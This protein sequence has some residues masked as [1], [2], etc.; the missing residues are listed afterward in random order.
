[1]TWTR[2]KFGGLVGAS[3]VAALRTRPTRSQTKAR[4]VVIGGGIGGATV[5]KYLVTTSAKLDVTLVEPKQKYTTCFFS[6]LYLAGVR[7]LE[8]LTHDYQTLTKAYGINVIHDAAAAID[9]VAKTVTLAG[10]NKLAYDRAVVAPGIAFKYD[11]IEG[12]DQA[13]TQTIPHA[14]NA[15]GSPHPADEKPNQGAGRRDRGRHWRRDRRQ[16]FGHYLRKTRCNIG[17]AKATHD[18]LLQQSLSRGRS[19]AR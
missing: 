11:G 4:V 2:R 10:G 5:A 14:W 7:S 3:L 6:N 8:S 16:V 15:R 17:R 18:V 1:M 13:A 9:P 12:Y 19:L